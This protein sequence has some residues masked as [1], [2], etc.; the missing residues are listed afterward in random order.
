MITSHQ[1]ALAL[2]TFI[3]ALLAYGITMIFSGFIQ[4]WIAKKLGDDTAEEAGFLSFNPLVYVDAVGFIFFMLIGF[5][6]GRT[7]PINPY[8]FTGRFKYLELIVTYAIRP[9]A[10]AI[11]A[12]GSLMM[13]VALLGGY[14]FQTP[15]PHFFIKHPMFAAAL[16]N[17]FVL[18]AQYSTVFTLLGLLLAFFRIMVIYFPTSM[19]AGHDPELIALIL[20]LIVLQVGGVYCMHGIDIVVQAIELTLRHWWFALINLLNV[21]MWYQ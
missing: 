15:L 5:G 7:V 20:T 1:L 8:N 17:V 9:F 13:L 2:S 14:Y 4:A 3:A 12:C 6:W 18:V 10:T 21:T 11:I 16:R 19:F